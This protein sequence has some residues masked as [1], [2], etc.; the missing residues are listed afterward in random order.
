M[1]ALK[2]RADRM[3]SAKP[4]KTV[5][6]KRLVLLGATGSI[7]DST[8]QVVRKHPDKLEIVA[9]A[10]HKNCAK[11]DAIA[12]E[13]NIRH[14]G[15]FDEAAAK[16]AKKENLFQGRTVHVGPA[17]LEELACLPTGDMVVAAVV[18]TLALKPTL[19]AIKA[20]KDIALAN[21]EILVL[22]GQFVMAAAK[23]H[24]VTIV[25]LDS[26]HNAIFQCLDGERPQDVAKLLLTASGGPFRDFT[27]EQMSA[28]TPAA[29]LKHPNWDMGPKVTI[30]SSTM[31]NKGLEVIEAHWLF[32]LPAERIQVVVHPQSIVHSM[33]QFV[34]GSIIAQLCPPSMTFPIQHSLLYPGRAEGVVPT[35]DFTQRFSLDFRPPNLDLFPCLRLAFAALRAEGAAPAAFN[36]ANEIAVAAFIARR[37][38]YLDIP[39]VI[40]ATLDS[41]P[42]SR[43]RNLDDILA[44][45]TAARQRAA[46]M[47]KKL[48]KRAK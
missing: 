25:P 23:K 42:K 29:A 45:D 26:E 30:D 8:L 15:V 14:V 44:A 34:D 41:L 10:A 20:G 19:A 38:S 6:K 22:A 24:G 12:R 40:E 21:K 9:I 1:T 7:G 33:V 28:I 32:G 2:L 18:G 46:A 48:E 11:L 3:P 37:I 27:R 43:P 36:A 4:S 31:A 17:G 35:L 16:S 39:R 5:R 47:V 13:F